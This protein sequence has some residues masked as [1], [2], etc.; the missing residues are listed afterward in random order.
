MRIKGQAEIIHVRVPAVVC[1]VVIRGPFGRHRAGVVHGR[2]G[3]GARRRVG[4]L[5]GGAAAA[6]AAAVGVPLG[7]AVDERAGRERRVV[8]RRRGQH[9]R[10]L[11]HAERELDAAE[12]DEGAVVEQGGALPARTT[13]ADQRTARGATTAPHCR[14]K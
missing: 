4:V 14:L 1:G 13:A 7:L 6:H 5:G 8:V 11:R 2:G 12:L 9:G 10:A 3:L